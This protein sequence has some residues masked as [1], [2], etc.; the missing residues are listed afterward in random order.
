ME[1]AHAWGGRLSDEGVE[2]TWEPDLQ[3]YATLDRYIANL[4]SDPI[5]HMSAIQSR[6][7]EQVPKELLPYAYEVNHEQ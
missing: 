7:R 4:F 2:G 5:H 6:A 3:K 1:L